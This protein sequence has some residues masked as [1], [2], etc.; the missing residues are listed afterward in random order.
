M[1]F[2]KL[3][4]AKKTE[5]DQQPK[6]WFFGGGDGSQINDQWGD[7]DLGKKKKKKNT[8]GAYKK[9]CMKELTETQE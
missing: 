7:H 2:I 9:W 1:L 3:C 4:T 6:I 5:M 8:Q